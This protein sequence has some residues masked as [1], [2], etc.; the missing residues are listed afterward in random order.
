MSDIDIT[1]GNI[2]NT[3]CETI[4]N[5]VNCRGVMGRGIALECRMRYPEMFDQYVE[6]CHHNRILILSQN[7]S[8]NDNYIWK[9]EDKWVFNFPT[10]VHW[11]QPSQIPYID[12]GLRKF[13]EFYKKAEINSVAFPLLGSSAGGL[14][15]DVVID[16]MKKHLSQINDKIEVEI[17]T[18]NPETEDPLFTDL[19]R[20]I[21]HFSTEEYKKYLGINTAQSKLIKQSIDSQNLHSMMSLQ[22]IKG[23]GEKT[24]IKLYE[25]ARK[26]KDNMGYQEKLDLEIE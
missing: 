13:V 2:F 1:H 18:F 19:Y 23:V 4:V 9:G 21:S 24:L 14:N 7:S 11:R 16:T 15:E 22:M 26:D 3:K 5:T 8:F 6:H 25:F 20:D 12:I 10:K 17:Y